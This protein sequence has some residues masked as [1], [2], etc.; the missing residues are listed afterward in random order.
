MSFTLSTNP[1]DCG[2]FDKVETLLIFNMQLTSLIKC[3]V[4]S[5]S[6]S[7]IN[8][9]CSMM[10]NWCCCWVIG[11]QLGLNCQHW[12]CLNIIGEFP[13]TRM[14]LLGVIHKCI[15]SEKVFKSL[16]HQYSIWK[17]FDAKSSLKQIQDTHFHSLLIKRVA[18]K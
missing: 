4:R 10:K 5:V 3:S 15:P 6:Q 18:Q 8:I 16:I 14:Y 7:V 17:M 11:P 12:K 9:R 13:A 1:S 2:W